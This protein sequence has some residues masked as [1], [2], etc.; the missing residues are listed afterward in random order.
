M[1]SK[2][3]CVLILSCHKPPR[4]ERRRRR[5]RCSALAFFVHL[6]FCQEPRCPRCSTAL[7]TSSTCISIPTSASPPPAS[8]WNTKV[9]VVPALI[10]WLP[11][12]WEVPQLEKELLGLPALKGG[13]E[14]LSK[15]GAEGWDAPRWA[16]GGTFLCLRKNKLLVQGWGLLL[17]RG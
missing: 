11:G 17:A 6:L 1:K 14:K 7:Q 3:L 13:R 5:G 15:D 4:R 10:L 2:G 9:R 16:L 8:T 12:V